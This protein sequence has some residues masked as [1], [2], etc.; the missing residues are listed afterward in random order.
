M[1]ANYEDTWFSKF[2][3]VVVLITLILALV[4]PVLP[5]QTCGLQ[6]QIQSQEGAPK[7]DFS[8]P[9]GEFLHRCQGS[10]PACASFVHG[11]ILG[12][13]KEF[14]FS[15]DLGTIV[16]PLILELARDVAEGRRAFDDKITSAL[17]EILERD[18]G[19]SEIVKKFY[20]S[21]PE[22]L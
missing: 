5:A 15:E 21:E 2:L 6:A 10:L 14:Q 9:I 20:L 22:P 3:G 7:Y 11:V 19:V 8:L 13:E 17:L 16:E 18:Y 1:S 12:S 4:A